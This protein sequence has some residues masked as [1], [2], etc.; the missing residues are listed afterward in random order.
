[1]CSVDTSSFE[2]YSRSS[3]NVTRKLGIKTDFGLGFLSGISP[4]VLAARKLQSDRLKIKDRQRA[5]DEMVEKG[6][7]RV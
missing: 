7:Y 2:R 4:T 5:F 1:M 3:L 6:E